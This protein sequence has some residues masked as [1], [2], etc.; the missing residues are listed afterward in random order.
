M[1]RRAT[2]INGEPSSKL[3]IGLTKDAV[4]VEFARRLN[5]QMVVK[6][7]N[8]SDMSREAEKHAPSGVRM[9]RDKISLYIRAKVLP[10][11]VHLQ[12][13]CTALDCKVSDLIPPAGT[14][15]AGEVLSTLDIKE[16]GEGMAW[17]TVNQSVPWPI[18]LKI[19]TL[20]RGDAN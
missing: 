8:Q 15:E 10:S 16:S 4:K 6:R 7:W 11:P 9:G 20:L 1:G 2:F 3:G 12:M 14:P 13:L 19:A 5:H 18:A 17:L